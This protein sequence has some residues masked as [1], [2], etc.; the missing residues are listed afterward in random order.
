MI[1]QALAAIGKKKKCTMQIVIGLLCDDK[2]YLISVH[3]FEGN[4][5]D[6]A[7]IGDQLQKLQK[8]FGIKQL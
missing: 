1:W 3:L 2:G 5:E 7:T 8:N 4:T 6:A